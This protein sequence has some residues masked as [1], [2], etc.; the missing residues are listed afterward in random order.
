[1]S[2]TRRTNLLLVVGALAVLVS[3]WVHFYLYFRGGYRGIAPESTF[4]VTISRSFAFT[5]VVAV[6]IAEALV[7]ATRFHALVLPAAASGALF[8]VGTLVAYFLSRTT[9]L[10]GFEE[11]STTAEAI[12]AMSAEVL[13]VLALTPVAIAARPRRR[14]PAT[15][16][17]T[18]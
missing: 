8:A 13:A 15:A 1:M 5:A 9:G 18:A 17:V 12:V 16:A 14:A 3:G 6:L 2:G 7:L 4:G 10:L 11:S